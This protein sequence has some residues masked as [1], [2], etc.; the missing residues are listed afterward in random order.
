MVIFYLADYV[1]TL[2]I[3]NIVGVKEPEKIVKTATIA[4]VAL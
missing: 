3:E 4:V 1:H 2:T